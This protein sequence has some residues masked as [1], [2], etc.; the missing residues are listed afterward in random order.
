M[1]VG[2]RREESARRYFFL[3]RLYL[4]DLRDIQ[5]VLEDLR[6]GG[7]PLEVRSPNWVAETVDE[8]ASKRTRD[9]VTDFDLRSSQPS[10]TVALKRHEASIYVANIDAL[11]VRGAV[12]KIQVILRRGQRPA[13]LRFFTSTVGSS[14][15]IVPTLAGLPLAVAIESRGGR[16]LAVAGGGAISLL[17]GLSYIF[18][19]WT[20]LRRSSLVFLVARA[21]RPGFLR[22]NRDQLIVGTILTGVGVLGSL[23]L[24]ALI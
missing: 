17:F 8:V 10:L 13:P 9:W 7:P 12:E 15:L 24:A 6:M 3:V 2:A 22:R 14:L 1:P 21:D 18:A 20:A 11:S 23:L 16:S 19:C 4:D 5:D